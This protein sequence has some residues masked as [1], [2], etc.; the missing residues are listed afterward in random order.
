MPLHHPG[1][2]HHPYLTYPHPLPAPP[3]TYLDANVPTWQLG[4]TAY[5]C[6]AFLLRR[7][8]KDG[9]LHML[10]HELKCQWHYLH[11]VRLTE[12][13]SLMVR[14]ANRF[15]QQL[16]NNITDVVLEWQQR[17]PLGRWWLRRSSS[18]WPANPQ[19]HLPPTWQTWFA[20]T[21]TQA[22]FTAGFVG[23]NEQLAFVDF[24]AWC[25]RP[26]NVVRIWSHAIQYVEPNL[27]ANWVNGSPQP[28]PLLLAL[29]AVTANML[30]PTFEHTMQNI[31]R[32][33]TT[34]RYGYGG[35]L[36]RHLYHQDDLTAGHH[37][38]LVLAN[39]NPDVGLYHAG[40]RRRAWLDILDDEV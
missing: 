6:G 1:P 33:Y 22:Q 18:T 36:M 17:R 14:L 39:V 10:A 25:L 21:V 11:G 30:K 26:V 20:E 35:T 7:D 8:W 4:A 31:F 2:G 32:R 12:V 27:V 15:R 24:H 5:F 29:R 37:G 38:D 3:V 9:N 23:T 34:H 13:K 40:A 16:L 28:L 19:G